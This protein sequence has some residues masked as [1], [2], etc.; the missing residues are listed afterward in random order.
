MA[1]FET[2]TPSEFAA[3]CAATPRPFLLDVRGAAEFEAGHVPG[4][5]HIR[6]HEIVR[7][8]DELPA[9]K[10]TRILVV[11]DDEKRI[12]AAANWFVLMGYAD[13]A[14][15]ACGFAA[16]TGPVEKGPPPPPR[17]RGPELR[18]L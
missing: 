14:V 1:H 12:R 6:V 11:G 4:S 13:V 3:A 8:R 16:W 17:P 15:L 5:H 7:H 2:L 18:V 10:I 9:R